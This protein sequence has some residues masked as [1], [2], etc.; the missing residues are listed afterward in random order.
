MYKVKVLMSTFNGEQYLEDQIKSIFNQKNVVVSLL[1]RDDGSTDNTI[2]IIDKLSKRFD[3]SFIKGKNVGYAR[4][5]MRLVKVASDADFYAFADQD[6]VWLPEKLNI[7]VANMNADHKEGPHLYMSQAIIVD[8]NLEPIDAKFHKRYISLDK[9]IA[10]NF[11]IGCTMVFDEAFRKIVNEKH[12]KLV[13]GAGHDYWISCLASAVGASISWD[14][15]GYVLY[16]QHGNNASGKIVSA[17]QALNAVKKILV[18]WRHVR[19]HIA[20][21]ILDNYDKYISE[22][23]KLVLK[24]AGNY[25]DSF[26]N[27]LKFLI[28]PKYMSKYFLVDMVTK[29][30]IFICAF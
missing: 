18:K 17:K 13:L 11:A 8:K 23:N 28:S 22:D 6:D 27:Y 21:Y 10:H 1:I 25:R 19:S 12:D 5:F 24:I 26:L 7:A 9:L 3:I 30:S 16:R 2:R 20:K 29:F 15:N 4:S 14:E